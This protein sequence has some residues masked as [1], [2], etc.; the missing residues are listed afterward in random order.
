[1]AAVLAAVVTAVSAVCAVLPWTMFANVSAS[2]DKD[3]AEEGG[4]LGM[5]ALLGSFAG[6][7]LAL[8]L[9]LLGVLTRRNTRGLPLS[10]A[11]MVLGGGWVLV[12]V[13]FWL[14]IAL[15]TR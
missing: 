7:F 14:A 11:A 1:V 4:I 5:L 15:G 2:T 9:G 8:C 12:A 3:R 6:A 10:I 13:Y